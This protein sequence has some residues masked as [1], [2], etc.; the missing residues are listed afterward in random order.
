MGCAVCGDISSVN[1][2]PSSRPREEFA[3]GPAAGIFEKAEA[4]DSALFEFENVLEAIK[5]AAHIGG[6]EFRA[7]KENWI[8]VHAAM[9][10]PF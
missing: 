5:V 1:C 9:L 4:D 8:A 7:F 6:Q 2:D 3:D 10:K